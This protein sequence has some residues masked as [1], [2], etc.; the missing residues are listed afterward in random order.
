MGGTTGY[1]LKM[2]PDMGRGRGCALSTRAAQ[3]VGGV[4][5]NVFESDGC[6]R[7]GVRLSA[8]HPHP[9][10][11]DGFR[12]VVNIEQG[13]LV[14]PERDDTEFQHLC[15]LQGHEHLLEHIKRKVR[16]Q[17]G[18]T[19]ARSP[20]VGRLRHSSSCSRRFHTTGVERLRGAFSKHHSTI[21]PT[22]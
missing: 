9:L 20:Q 16:G 4:N 10:H 14:K 19:P 15:F 22:I 18:H 1:G 13:G 12:K 17:R 11:A 2:C 5:R 7:Q 3:K 6:G 8:L 21:C